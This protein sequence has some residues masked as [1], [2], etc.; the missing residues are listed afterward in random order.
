M[1]DR[2]LKQILTTRTVGTE[3]KQRNAAI[4]LPLIEVEGKDSLLFE[5]RSQQLDM[6]PGEVC[7]PGGR[8]EAGETPEEA[9]VRE[10]WEELHVA[11]EQIEILGPM[12]RM[13]HFSGTVYPL[14][15]RVDSLALPNLK[16]NEDEVEEVF[17]VP[18]E[19]FLTHPGKQYTYYM[20]PDNLEELPPSL[21]SYVRHYRQKYVT[22]AWCYSGHTIW[23]MT[24]RVVNKLL[25][26]FQAES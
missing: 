5:V 6:Q 10:I 17:T 13:V 26:F 21:A 11:Q 25:G 15:G 18:L 24:A 20:S 12:D 3:R 22:P 14:L 23:G 9:A 8:M 16:L 1:N 7:F 19:F 4:L 2:Q